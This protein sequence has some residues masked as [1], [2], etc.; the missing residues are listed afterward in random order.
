M[1]G[2]SYMFSADGMDEVTAMSSELEASLTG[3][4]SFCAGV[5]CIRCPSSFAVRT[6]IVLA[7][8][9]TLT[10]T[11][12]PV[13]RFDGDDEAYLKWMSDNPTGYVLNTKRGDAPST[14]IIH[15]SGCAHIRV[16]RNQEGA[17]GFTQRGGIKLCA[18]EIRP[19]VKYLQT[20]RT[21]PIIKVMNCRSCGSLPLDFNI[22]RM[23]EEVTGL[24]EDPVGSM[25]VQV[26]AF[27]QDPLARAVCLQHHGHACSVCSAD[28]DRLYGLSGDGA[29]TVHCIAQASVPFA[30]L[31]PIRDLRPVCPTCHLLIH[32]GRETPLHV[33][34]L[35]KIMSK[36]RIRWHELQ[37]NG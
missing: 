10:M 20:F 9:P 30:M 13:I 14:C 23:P 33:E 21:V 34:D 36:A 15:R 25:I 31:D 24:T 16:L 12:A 2:N 37:M 6:P 26:H 3:V 28:L 35:K 22:E 11:A 29:M 7:F 19:L 18:E 5:F 17:G 1:R 32:R 8:V 4:S 27:E